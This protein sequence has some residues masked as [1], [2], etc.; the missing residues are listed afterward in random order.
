MKYKIIAA[1]FAVL[2]LLMKY[3]SAS[4]LGLAL[5]LPLS[6]RR[7]NLFEAKPGA[8]IVHP[9]FGS[10]G[11]AVIALEVTGREQTLER[12]L[13]IASNGFVRY[14]EARRF[15][16]QATSALSPLELGNWLALFLEKDF[17]HLA[18][19]YESA[20]APSALR[21]RLTFKRGSLEKNMLTDSVSAPASVQQILARCS[22]YMA[23]IRNTAVQLSLTA[24]RDTLAHGEE[25]R[26]T[27]TVK[28][29]HAQPVQLLK[30]EPLAEFFVVAPAQLEQQEREE[31]D[32][33]TYVW[34]ESLSLDQVH[35]A[36]S[37]E[38][39]AG[40][41]LEYGTSWNGRSS[42]GVSLAGAYLLAARLATI[43][44]GVTAW[45]QIYV[46]PQ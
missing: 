38:L 17:L 4:L 18:A 28:N 25:A 10:S 1:I 22:Q 3:L 11:E 40:A 14:R 2:P 27:L 13:T 6:C 16:G 8:P 43:P 35:L 46:K 30:G 44:G 29:P 24:S 37:L 34:R 42:A 20:T 12:A 31:G 39:A 41:Q 19:R 5:L 26:L 9:L 36:Q 21:Y 33:A 32:R 23:A 45:R 15:E 7:S